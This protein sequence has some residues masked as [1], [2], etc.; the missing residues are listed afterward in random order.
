MAA[1][2]DLTLY[3]A[4]PSRS[5]RCRWALLEAGLDFT[6]IE[7][8]HLIR[9]DELK[10]VHPM[11]KLPAAMIGGRPL[12]ESAAIATYIAD[13]APDRNLVAPSG[14]WARALHDQWVCFALTELEAHL[15][16]TA[17]N[18]FVYP[19]ERR[20]PVIFEQNAYEFRRAAQVVEAAL[21][22][23]DYLVDNRFS[24]TDI[25]V[26]Y[27]L[28]WGRR[29]DLLGDLPNLGKYLERLFER[30]HCTLSRE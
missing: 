7:G 24:V 15:W 14:T 3:E 29:Q 10:Q 22:E 9:S 1:K 26:S 16:S 25:I 11:G 8:R 21:A 27:T 28:N 13:Q 19:K 5:A 12:F 4:A 20:L 6:S 17:R 18:T 30:P 2:I 23:A